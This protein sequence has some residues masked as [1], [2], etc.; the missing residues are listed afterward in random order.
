[1]LEQLLSDAPECARGDNLMWL[2]LFNTQI[3]HCMQLP[4]AQAVPD[5]YASSLVPENGI[6]DPDAFSRLQY[7]IS[8]L[9]VVFPVRPN[10]KTQWKTV[11]YTVHALFGTHYTS[12]SSS[13]LHFTS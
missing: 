10:Q 4:T 5:T 9:K 3:M 12:L 7:L 1:M 6:T 8:L 13:G 2:C 11:L